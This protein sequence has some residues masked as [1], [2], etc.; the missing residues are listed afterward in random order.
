M[1]EVKTF[2]IADLIVLL[3]KVLGGLL[4][5]SYAL[6]ASGVYDIALIIVSLVTIKVKENKKYKGIIS[7]LL[8]LVVI[9]LGIGI[10][11]L[12]F[13]NKINRVSFFII[14]FILLSIIVRYIVSCFYTNIS[15]QKKKGLLSYG[16]INSTFDFVGYGIILG[17][18]VLS[19]ISKWVGFLKYA[20]RV[21]TIIVAGFAIY[22]GLVIIVNSFR[23]L[24]DK[25]T[26][27]DD[28]YKEEILKRN[29]VK[30]IDKLELESYGGIRKVTCD[31]ELK[32]GISMID[33][34]T[35][36]VTLQDYL[37]KLADVV[38]INLVDKKSTVKKKTKVRSLKQDARN[39][40]SGNSKTNTKKKNTKQK[41]KKR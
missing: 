14:L 16:K 10:I 24:E 35:F 20:D 17:V 34:N 36:I 11:F 23:Y 41:N 6:I 22:K 30:K 3:I 5:H 1:K 31:I 38:K 12:S 32:D 19:K 4:T 39:S 21:G 8:G 15:Y 40:R 29:E 28:K 27:I 18:L 37:L 7:S 9:I 2:I 13:V 26:T 25:E 33:V